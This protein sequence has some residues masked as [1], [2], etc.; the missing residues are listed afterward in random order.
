M[1]RKYKKIIFVEQI[2][3]FLWSGE[4]KTKLDLLFFY[5]PYKYNIERFV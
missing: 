1:H 4:S 2:F 3:L 5:E